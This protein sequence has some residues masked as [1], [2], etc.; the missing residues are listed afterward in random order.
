MESGLNLA[1]VFFLAF[2]KLAGHVI[3]LSEISIL[4]HKNCLGM[5][6]LS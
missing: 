1:K 3:S 4:V 6:D 5:E 2:V